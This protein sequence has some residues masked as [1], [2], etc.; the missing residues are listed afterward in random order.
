MNTCFMFVL[1]TTSGFEAHP[2]SHAW[3][4]AVHVELIG[5]CSSRQK[6]FALFPGISDMTRYQQKRAALGAIKRS[7]DDPQVLA[8][9]QTEPLLIDR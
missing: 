9:P 1:R 3:F 7:S 4:C 5:S 2:R 8:N 6:F